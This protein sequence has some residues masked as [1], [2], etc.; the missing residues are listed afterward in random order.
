MTLHFEKYQGAGNDFIVIDDRQETFNF[1]DKTLISRL[2]DRK[3]GIGADGL[4]LLRNH[5]E[6]DFRMI[7]FN[8]DGGEVSFCGNGARCI[9]RFAHS[10]G[11]FEE[12]TIFV[13]KDGI[14]EA[15]IAKNG[16]YLKMIDVEKIEPYQEDYL[17]NT[18]V[19]HYVTFRENIAEINVFNLGHKI[20][21]SDDF[22]AEGINVNFVQIQDTENHLKGTHPKDVDFSD[23]KPNLFVRTYE[24]GVEDE[25][26]ACGTG[27][28]ACVLASYVFGFQSPVSVKVMGGTLGVWFEKTEKGFKN[29]YLAGGSDFVFK[30]EIHV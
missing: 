22:R 11:I 18:G 2:C 7:Y 26:L 9:V 21:N 16:I 5:P 6:T 19:P 25:T 24:R 14:H 12:K 29:I 28:T 20:R 30:G 1:R 8:A 13:A 27:V 10:L 23:L 4:L 15:G 3:F 17:T